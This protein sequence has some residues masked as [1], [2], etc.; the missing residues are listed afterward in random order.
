MTLM[1]PSPSWRSIP[2]A[3]YS[4]L[5]KTSLNG[6]VVLPSAWT[7]SPARVNV[8]NKTRGPLLLTAGGQDHTVPKAITTST[9]KLYHKSPAITDY[10]EFH[11]R[12]HSLTIDSGWR[13]VAQ[14]A[15]DWLQK[16]HN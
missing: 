1:T 14:Y 6:A 10:V 2:R 11:D 5:S 4:T 12:G 16:R 8:H 13:E 15:V 7:R 3:I 9:R